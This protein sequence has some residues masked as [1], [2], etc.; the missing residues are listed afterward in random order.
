LLILNRFP[1]P[2][3]ESPLYFLSITRKNPIWDDADNSTAGA[4]IQRFDRQSHLFGYGSAD[5]S[6]LIL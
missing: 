1:L 4:C 2:S 5:E 6:A 3:A